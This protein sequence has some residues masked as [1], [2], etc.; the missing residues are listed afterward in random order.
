MWSLWWVVAR[1]AMAVRQLGACATVVV[2]IVHSFT[3]PFPHAILS[4]E[5]YGESAM[6]FYKLFFYMLFFGFTRIFLAIQSCFSFHIK[7]LFLFFKLWPYDPLRRILW[8]KCNTDLQIILFS[9]FSSLIT[10][11]L[12]FFLH[13]IGKFTSIPPRYHQ[14]NNPCGKGDER[15]RFLSVFEID[16]VVWS[17]NYQVLKNTL[18]RRCVAHISYYMGY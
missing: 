18:N 6:V 16:A 15:G 3:W 17:L 8:G 12:C 14:S 13:I 1:Y 9:L 7:L 10:S 2:F 11:R 4:W 5:L